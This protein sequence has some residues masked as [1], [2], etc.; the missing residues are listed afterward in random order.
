M[1]AI[2]LRTFIMSEGLNDYIVQ[3]GLEEIGR[4]L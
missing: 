1:V 2:D 3:N 4:V